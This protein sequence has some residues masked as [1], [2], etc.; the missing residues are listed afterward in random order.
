MFN[1]YEAGMTFGWPYRQCDPLRRPRDGALSHRRSCTLFLSEPADYDGGELV[2]EAA[3]GLAPVKLRAGD[4]VLYSA[5]SVHKVLPVTR[6][7]RWASFFWV[8]SMIRDDGQRTLLHDF[9]QSIIAAR[10]SLGD[11]HRSVIALTGTY[12]NLLRMWAE[13]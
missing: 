2:V 6:G 8:Q 11:E 10:A 1:R 5:S 13:V 7:A 4:L 3:Y 9:D 12:H